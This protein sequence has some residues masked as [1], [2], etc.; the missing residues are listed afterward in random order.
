[1]FPQLFQFAIFRPEIVAPL[2]NAVCLV[3]R[4]VRDVP[5]QRAFQKRFEHQALRRHVKHPVLAAVQSAQSRDRFIS[6]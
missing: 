4:D 2:A 5:V 6:I 1:M 3:N